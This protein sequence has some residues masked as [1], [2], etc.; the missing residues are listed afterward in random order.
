MR[1]L[2]RECF[3]D[4]GA[5][6]TVEDLRDRPTAVTVTEHANIAAKRSSVSRKCSKE[7]R[8]QRRNIRSSLP[9]APQAT[10]VTRVTNQIN[11][12]SGITQFCGA[13]NHEQRFMAFHA[14]L[15]RY[16]KHPTALNTTSK[17]VR[18]PA[19]VND[20]PVLDITIDTASDVPCIAAFFLRQHPTL[21]NTKMSAVP[22]N[23]INLRSADGS[24]L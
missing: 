17:R 2:L 15:S 6:Q 13:I 21:K 22:P 8:R 12:S 4:S 20:H 3:S 10:H 14:S 19:R 1:I 18:V 23:A 9:L 11:D 5:S 16:P 7:K 24:Q